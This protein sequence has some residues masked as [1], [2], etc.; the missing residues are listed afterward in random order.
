MNP[1][2]DAF[3]VGTF[4]RVLAALVLGVAVGAAV[5]ADAFVLPVVGSV[6]GLVVAALG[7]A[8]A[9]LFRRGDG[10]GCSGDCDC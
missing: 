3:D 10:C 5:A 1:N 4:G 2:G 7:V 9:A 6:P 8:A